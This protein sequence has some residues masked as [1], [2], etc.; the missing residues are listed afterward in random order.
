VAIKKCYFLGWD[1]LEAE[2]YRHFWETY[3]IFRVEE[4]LLFACSL[5]GSLFDLGDGSSMFLRNVDIHLPVWMVSYSR[6]QK[7]LSLRCLQN[8]IT[9]CTHA[10]NDRVLRKDK[11]VL[12]LN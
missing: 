5:V 1:E 12:V 10:L 7:E 2:V 9:G 3:F 11:V 6:N 4:W 8:L